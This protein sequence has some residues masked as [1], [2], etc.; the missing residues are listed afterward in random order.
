MEI[1]NIKRLSPLQNEKGQN[2]ISEM[3]AKLHLDNKVLK[4]QR[5]LWGLCN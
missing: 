3:F 1:K 5:F 4:S 2:L